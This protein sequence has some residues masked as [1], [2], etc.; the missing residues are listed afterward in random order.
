[1]SITWLHIPAMPGAGVDEQWQARRNNRSIAVFRR[2]YCP[3]H[4][5]CTHHYAEGRVQK[6]ECEAPSW[7]G[8]IVGPDGLVQDVAITTHCDLEAAR[9]H[10]EKIL[11]NLWEAID[12]GV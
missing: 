11:E 1:M 2:G 8:V 9:G 5:A 7:E 10:F 12:A 3:T 4:C 6:T